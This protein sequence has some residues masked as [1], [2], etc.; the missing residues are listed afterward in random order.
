MRDSTRRRP[1]RSVGPTAFGVSRFLGGVES[2]LGGNVVWPIKRWNSP[3]RTTG[4]RALAHRSSL[5][6][7]SGGPRWSDFAANA[8]RAPRVRSG[9]GEDGDRFIFDGT[10]ACRPWDRRDERRQEVPR[11]GRVVLPNCPIQTE[12]YLLAC[13]RYVE[14]NPVRA[15]MVSRPEDY[16]WSSYISR[17][18]RSDQF[19]WLDTDPCFEGLGDTPQVRASRYAE[20]V[21]SAIPPGEWEMIRSALQRGQLTGNERFIDEVAAIIGRRIEHRQPGRPRLDAEE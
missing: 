19:T 11:T 8:S 7:N 14:L 1:A 3:V 6:C 16:Q 4:C 21:R 2:L 5:A 18:G 17:V 20:F 9:I 15:R 13:C 10:D 12:A